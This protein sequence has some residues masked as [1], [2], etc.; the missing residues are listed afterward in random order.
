[1]LMDD[2]SLNSGGGTPDT[3]GP[4]ALPTPITLGTLYDIANTSV[5]G[6][7]ASSLVGRQGWF[8][9][10][11]PGEKVINEATVFR[12]ANSSRLRFGTYS[13]LAQLNACTPPGLGRLNEIDSL[14]GDLLVLPG[15]TLPSRTYPN[16]SGTGFVSTSIG[17]TFSSNGTNSNYQLV[18]I[19]QNSRGTLTGTEGVPTKIYWYMEP[20]Q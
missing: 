13:P 19:G 14:T 4:S 6:V 2:P 3:G 15:S 17:V 18:S 16:Y 1:M 7:A 5:S 9:R 12:I 8:R 11:D 10:L 20:E